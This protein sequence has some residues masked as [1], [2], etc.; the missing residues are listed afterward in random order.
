MFTLSKE[1]IKKIGNNLYEW[2][3]IMD[4]CIIVPVSDQE[5]YEE[6]MDYLRKVTKKLQKG[7]IKSIIEPSM[8]DTFRDML[9]KEAREDDE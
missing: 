4:M 9:E 6:A 3:T 2:I 5:D 8:I 7:K 1:A